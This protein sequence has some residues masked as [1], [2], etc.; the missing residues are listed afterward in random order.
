MRQLTKL[1]RVC[2]CGYKL[3]HQFA[4]DRT[5]HGH[6]PAGIC[7]HRGSARGQ[8][9]VAYLAGRANWIVKSRL[10]EQHKLREAAF[11]NPVTLD[12]LYWQ[13]TYPSWAGLIG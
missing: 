12:Q 13:D 5:G 2:D 11:R 10:S 4:L 6:A 7:L 8:T 9:K 1:G 3:D